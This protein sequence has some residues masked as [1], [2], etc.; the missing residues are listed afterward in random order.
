MLRY[1]IGI[2]RKHKLKL[3]HRQHVQ[4]L[5]YLVLRD[6][7]SHSTR[8][9]SGS[10]ATSSGNTKADIGIQSIHSLRAL[11]VL[12]HILSLHTAR[13]IGRLIPHIERQEPSEMTKKAS[14]P[15]T[16]YG[17]GSGNGNGSTTTNG[18]TSTTTNGNTR[19]RKRSLSPFAT[20]NSRPRRGRGSTT[21]A[22][23]SR[24]P[25]KKDARQTSKSK[26][27]GPTWVGDDDEDDDEGSDADDGHLNPYGDTYG[28]S[29]GI[30]DGD[31]PKWMKWDTVRQ[32]RLQR[33]AWRMMGT[34]AGGQ[35]GIWRLLWEPDEK[36]KGQ[37]KGGA[38]VKG[39][40]QGGSGDDG[41]DDDDEDTEASGGER[42]LSPGFWRLLGWLLD[43]WEKD[44][45]ETSTGE[46]SKASS[47]MI[48][49]GEYIT[50]SPFRTMRKLHIAE[51]LILRCAESSGIASSFSPL[52]LLQLP[53]YRSNLTSEQISDSGDVMQVVQAAYV[54]S[55]DS[56]HAQRAKQSRYESENDDDPPALAGRL[57]SLVSVHTE[58]LVHGKYLLTITLIARSIRFT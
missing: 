7:V 19:S 58:S 41:E 44:A 48:G 33:E 45:R 52:F 49:N 42:R 20:V 22:S 40:T 6:R 23:R 34:A 38:K 39:P 4:I 13:D 57:L 5:L 11:E 26:T 12:R 1:L 54:V 3:S 17:G 55:E 2:V 14:G 9:N 47:I 10:K 29:N 27:T 24:S 56:A 28:R 43:L 46:G 30:G 16:V 32:S 35:K 36:G 18:N 31:T 25:V 53:Q 15:S 8:T 37:G 50:F 21:S 51:L